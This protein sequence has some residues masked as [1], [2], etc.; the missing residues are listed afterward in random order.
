MEFRENF[1]DKEITFELLASELEI[2]NNLSF[3]HLVMMKF[4]GNEIKCGWFQAEGNDKY[5]LV[6]LSFPDWGATSNAKAHCNQCIGQDG[7]IVSSYKGALVRADPGHIE[8]Q[9]MEQR[10]LSNRL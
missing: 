7:S 2:I 3:I 1:K 5:I 6:E 8:A 4:D 9:S 10:A